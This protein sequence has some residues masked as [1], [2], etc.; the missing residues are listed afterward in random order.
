M[1]PCSGD[2][3][4]GW[5]VAVLGGNMV[6]S[7][8]NRHTALCSSL[9]V[10]AVGDKIWADYCHAIFIIQDRYLPQTAHKILN[11]DFKGIGAPTPLTFSTHLMLAES[12][13]FIHKTFLRLDRVFLQYFSKQLKNVLW[14]KKLKINAVSVSMRVSDDWLLFFPVSSESM[15]L[16]MHLDIGE[17]VY[18]LEGTDNPF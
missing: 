15:S 10:M 14:I 16:V 12:R 6:Q 9:L 13:V 7:R 18:W 17:N 3:A 2:E 1:T 4:S 8:A 5:L 11:A